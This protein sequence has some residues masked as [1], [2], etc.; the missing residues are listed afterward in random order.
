M[1]FRIFIVDELKY[2]FIIHVHL[3]QYD[4]SK[5]VLN[6]SVIIFIFIFQT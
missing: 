5:Y 3:N 1:M 2:L 6:Q 4:T